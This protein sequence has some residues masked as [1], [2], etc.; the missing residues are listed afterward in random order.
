M[1]NATKFET[2]PQRLDHSFVDISF[3]EPRLNMCW[4]FTFPSI[5]QIKAMSDNKARTAYEIGR[6][7][8][9]DDIGEVVGISNTYRFVFQSEDG[10][11]SLK[12]EDVTRWRTNLEDYFKKQNC[13]I[14]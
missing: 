10:E 1:Q 7:I 13:L 4:G 6:F 5:E 3:W 2:Y 12:G 9:R 8:K 11:P 14:R